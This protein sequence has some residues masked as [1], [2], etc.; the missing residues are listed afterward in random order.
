[1]PSEL[2]DSDRIIKSKTTRNAHVVCI[3]EVKA[4]HHF[5]K[6]TDGK[7]G[8]AV[9][10]NADILGFCGAFYTSIGY[11]AT[12]DRTETGVLERM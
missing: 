11:I 2:S 1:M 9:W 3:W 10:S 6:Y 12:N 7:V 4:A 8:T 5:V